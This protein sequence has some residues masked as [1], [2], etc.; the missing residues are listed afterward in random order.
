VGRKQVDN[1]LNPASS[2][3]SDQ[4]V[5]LPTDSERR[6]RTQIHPF[7]DLGFAAFAKIPKVLFETRICL[8]HA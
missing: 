7:V 4:E 2:A 8:P 6:P 1:P 5:G 3:T